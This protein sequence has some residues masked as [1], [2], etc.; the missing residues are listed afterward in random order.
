M[1]LTEELIGQ[2]VRPNDEPDRSASD[3]SLVRLLAHRR[4]PARSAFRAAFRRIGNINA[5]PRAFHRSAD[6]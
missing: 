6:L 3:L 2:D 1:T 4:S 5:A